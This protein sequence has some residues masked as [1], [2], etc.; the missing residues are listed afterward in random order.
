MRV[1]R[2]AGAVV[3]M[4][5]GQPSSR[6]S[7]IVI[8]TIAL[9]LCCLLPALSTSA[10]AQRRAQRASA[11]R[12]PVVIPFELSERGHIFLHVRVNSSE[13]LW[14]VLDSGS[15]DTV[16]NNRLIKKLNL[17][18]EAEGEAAGAGSEQAAVLT[19]GVS[20][21]VG[22]VRLTRQDIPAIDFQRLEK[23]IGREIDGMLGYDF[24]RRFVVEVDYEALSMKIHNAAGY[25]YRGSGQL[26]PIT[27][28]A[29]HPH[30]A[31]KVTLPGRDP[32]EGRFIVD[33]GAGGVTL[34]F[35][36]SFVKSHKLL[37]SIQILETKSLAAVGGPHT[38]SYARGE[39]IQMGRLR[40][41][42]PIIG[43][44]Q[45]PRGSQNRSN[46]AGLVGTKFL[47]RFTVIYDDQR[48]RIIFEPNRSF[49]IAEP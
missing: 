44:S 46:I 20:L 49:A 3:L 23:S 36:N 47:R 15:G 40:L 33:G 39:S 27:T 37:D 1:S 17:K 48:H 31:L 38:I 21:D 24:I 45:T 25:R 26:M 19:T 42:N 8:R 22:G 29:D 4:H 18:V 30:I 12:S 35:S 41:T 10:I 6:L 14:F 32:V 28:E 9:F 5:N 43:F 11:T 13:P 16:L 34:E 2:R 7:K